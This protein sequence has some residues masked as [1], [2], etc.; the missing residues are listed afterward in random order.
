MVKG[1]FCSI[2]RTFLGLLTHG[3]KQ[4]YNSIR[5]IPSNR[6]NSNY[7]NNSSIPFP[8]HKRTIIVLQHSAISIL[9][10]LALHLCLNHTVAFALPS[11]ISPPSQALM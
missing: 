7:S 6:N 1:I 3:K 5:V 10:C 9:L 2:S 11:F 8:S 4:S